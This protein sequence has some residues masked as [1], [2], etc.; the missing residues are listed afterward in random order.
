MRDAAGAQHLLP[1]SQAG[2]VCPCWLR[3]Q[4]QSCSWS[5]CL[6]PV[7]LSALG[8]GLQRERERKDSIIITLSL[9]PPH[10]CLFFLE[11]VFVSWC[12]PYQS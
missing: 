10:Q 5:V 9:C 2:P 1:M 4:L 12:S 3:Q 6:Q 11:A 8:R 7:C